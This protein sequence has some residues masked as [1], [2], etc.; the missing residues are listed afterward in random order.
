MQE[1]GF[2]DEA[3]A[4]AFLKARKRQ[5]QHK[6][7]SAKKRLLQVWRAQDAC[8]LIHPFNRADWPRCSCV[9]ARRLGCACAAG[10][11]CTSGALEGK[12]GGQ[13][14]VMRIS[15]GCCVDKAGPVMHGSPEVT[16]M[17]CEKILLHAYMPMH[18]TV[19]SDRN[20]TTNCASTKDASQLSDIA[21][22]QVLLRN[23]AGGT[24]CPE[25]LC[26]SSCF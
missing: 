8:V 7:A 16:A 21:H 13:Q 15:A 3:T 14:P 4:E 1:W 23:W 12:D 24:V 5:L 19:G 25:L 18:S 6:A 22:Y 26:S 11:Q 10:S 20:S 9:E 2:K 17:E